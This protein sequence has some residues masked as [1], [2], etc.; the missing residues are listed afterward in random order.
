MLVVGNKTKQP[1]FSCKLSYEGDYTMS[2]W[3]Q[4]PVLDMKGA[5]YL[6]N[7]ENRMDLGPTQ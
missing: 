4:E 1:M 3:T 5:T 7:D 6:K 2:M